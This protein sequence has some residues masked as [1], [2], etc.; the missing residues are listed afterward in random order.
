MQKQYFLGSNTHEGFRGA[1]EKVRAAKKLV[2]LKGGAGSGK[3]TVM[4]K[5]AS[6]A[7][8]QNL[9]T[10]IYRCSSDCASLDAVFIPSL[11]AAV[12][13][14][15]APHVVEAEYPAI[16]QYV[17]NL[18]DEASSKKLQP[19]AETVKNCVSYKK[20]Y[21]TNAY[22][23]L[24]CAYLLQNNLNG[25]IADNLSLSK[26][27]SLSDDIYEVIKRAVNHVKNETFVSAI[28]DKGVINYY[29]DNFGG[30]THVSITSE[31]SFVTTKVL[32]TLIKRLDSAGTPFT[33]CISPLSYPAAEAVVVGDYI[34]ADAC[35][36]P[37]SEYKFDTSPLVKNFNRHFFVVDTPVVEAHISSAVENINYAHLTHMEI[38]KIY[39]PS[40]DWSDIN[41]KT[42]KI[43][44]IVFN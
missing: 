14:G 8:E 4:K 44:N 1:Y 40:M 41:K 25:I 38:E 21:F 19:Y 29:T 23:H 18:L 11:S 15:T 43:F 28:S 13:D 39:Y 30:Y 10:E 6:F 2:I 5:I 37:D 7:E 26:V 9:D 12:V 32:E 34:I 20:Q 24:K 17:I 16:G 42:E 3:S 35:V 22:C 33:R 36:L 27:S 31:F